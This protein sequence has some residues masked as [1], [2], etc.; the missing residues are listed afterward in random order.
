[1]RWSGGAEH[2]DA[3]QSRSA[4]ASDRYAGHWGQRRSFVFHSRVV[5]L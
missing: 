4:L 3:M 1:M 5:L 2:H